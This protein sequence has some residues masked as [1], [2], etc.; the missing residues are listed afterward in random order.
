QAPWQPVNYEGG[1]V[2]AT[3]LEDALI[4][5]R[6]LLTARLATMIGLPAIAK[7]V[8]DFD[9]MDRMPLYYSMSLGAGETTLLRLTS[10]YAMLDNGGHWLLPSVIDT[11]Q[12][13]NG[14]IVYQKGVKACA[15]CF[16]A[17][18]PSA[19]PDSGTLYRAAGPADPSSIRLPNASYADNAVV[20]K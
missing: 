2:G 13:R 10:A 8:Q 14:K 19:G 6:N 17:A 15:G 20:Y 7:T 3:T 18:G 9:I 11:V 16:I 12:D 1:Y 4:H 5:S